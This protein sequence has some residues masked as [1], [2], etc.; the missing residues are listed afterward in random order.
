MLKYILTK[1]NSLF[2]LKFNQ[3]LNWF[4]TFYVNVALLPLKD[5]MKFPIL[6]YGKCYVCSLQGRI[7]FEDTIQKGLLIIGKSDPVRSFEGSTVINIAGDLL[8]KG[9]AEI[10]RGLHL[11]IN[12]KATLELGNHVFIGDN[13]TIT[14]FKTD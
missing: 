10:R 4:I 12:P 2:Y 3:S 5:A 13:T 6:I 11:Q 14:C 9:K 8:I 7:I 1:L